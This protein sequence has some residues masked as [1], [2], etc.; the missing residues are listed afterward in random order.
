MTAIIKNLN[1]R[2]QISFSG[3]FDENLESLSYLYNYSSNG[4][5][6][7]SL[8]M[9]FFWLDY[10]SSPNSSY[11]P[12]QDFSEDS[13]NWYMAPVM[14]QTGVLTPASNVNTSS[15]HRKRG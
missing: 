14:R 15:S 12:A 6:S 10:A 5:K 4:A 11:C 7:L 8:N 3:L 9:D 13:S 1:N 2:T